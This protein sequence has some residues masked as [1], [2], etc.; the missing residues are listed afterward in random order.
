MAI[1]DINKLAA[2][3]NKYPEGRALVLYD[4]VGYLIK[5]RRDEIIKA[6]GID[7]RSLRIYF[8][9]KGPNEKTSWKLI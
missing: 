2:I 1:S 5:A 8:I 7:D 9:S 4:D 3:R 6:R